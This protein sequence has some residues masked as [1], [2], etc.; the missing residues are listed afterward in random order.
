MPGLASNQIILAY[1]SGDPDLATGTARPAITPVAGEPLLL[2]CGLGLQD[3]GDPALPL[4]QVQ[5]SAGPADRN[6]KPQYYDRL[7][8]NQR[9]K[10][11]QFRVLLLPFHAGEPLPAIVADAGAN[12]ASLK[13]PQQAD[14]LHF[15]SGPGE[16]T[17]VQVLRA[18]REVLTSK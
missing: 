14:D 16:Q 10:A 1:R 5:R 2:V 17:H 13:W 15:A 18:G 7:V 4:I 6:G 11:V 12:D 8:I 3:S 9:A